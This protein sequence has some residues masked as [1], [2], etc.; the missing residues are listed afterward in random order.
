MTSKEMRRKIKESGKKQ[1]QIAAAAGISEATIIRW[2]REEELPI[3]RQKTLTEAL[4]KLA[5][6]Q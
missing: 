4:E 3:E 2:L 1:W 5:L 6:K